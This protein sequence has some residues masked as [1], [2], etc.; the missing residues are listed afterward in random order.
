MISRKQLPAGFHGPTSFSVT[1]AAFYP[2]QPPGCFYRLAAKKVWV[3]FLKRQSRDCFHLVAT[4]GFL[5]TGADHGSQP[6]TV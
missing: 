5:L 4:T 6:A 2:N 1:N 3:A